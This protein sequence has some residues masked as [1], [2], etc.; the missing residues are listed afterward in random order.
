MAKAWPPTLERLMGT[1]RGN[2][3]RGVVLI[4]CWLNAACGSRTALDLCSFGGCQDVGAGGTLSSSGGD[5]GSSSGGAI[6]GSGGAIPSSGGVSPGSGGVASE[7]G[8]QAATGGAGT[9]GGPPDDAP[10]VLLLMDASFSMF[11]GSVWAPTYEALLGEGGPIERYENRVRFGF[12][13][14]RGP[15]Q[16]AEDDPACAEIVHVPSALGNVASIR[17]TY[18][19]LTTKQG[20]WETPTGHAITRVVQDLLGE[21]PGLRK[22]IFLFSDGA[23]DTCLTTSPQCGQDRAVFAVQQAARAGVETRPFGIGYGMEYGCD[24]SQARCSEDHFQ[25]LAN[26]GRGLPVQAPP[27]AYASLPCAAET[28]GVLLADYAGEGAL[29]PFSWAMSPDEARSAVLAALAEIVEH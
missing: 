17:E 3:G 16:V 10:V 21:E 23:P 25:D 26:A 24:T 11:A 28:G 20:Y 18:G 22:Y 13:S 2:A 5:S 29:T 4:A 9:G 12:S 7:T 27:E 14:Y 19:A 1:T 8:G 15:G 6:Q